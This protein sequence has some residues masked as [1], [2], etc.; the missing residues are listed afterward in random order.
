MNTPKTDAGREL[1]TKM[2]SGRL[3]ADYLAD[4][5]RA[6]EREAYVRGYHIGIVTCIENGHFVSRDQPEIVGALEA[7]R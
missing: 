3:R 1:L 2:E 5:I 7:L 6:V 4:A